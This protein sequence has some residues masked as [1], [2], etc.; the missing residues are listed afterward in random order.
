M[1]M[2]MRESLSAA[3]VLFFLMLS[4]LLPPR[5]SSAQPRPQGG[6]GELVALSKVA[7]SLG[8]VWRWER[9]FGRLICTRHPG[10]LRF[11]QDK[12]FY[13]VNGTVGKLPEAPRRIGPTLYLP[14]SLAADAFSQTSSDGVKGEGDSSAVVNLR[15]EQPNENIHSV[16]AEKKSNGTLVSIRLADSLPFDVTYFYPNLTLNFFGGK[17]DTA[18]IKQAQRIGLINSIS[19]IQFK[20]S[21]QVTAL[22]NHEIEEPMVEYMQ[23]TRTVMVALRPQKSKPQPSKAAPSPKKTAAQSG[24]TPIQAATPLS[25][26]PTVIVIDPGHGGKDPGAISSSGI[27]EKDVVLSIALKLREALLKKNGRLVIYMTREIDIFIPLSARTKFA[28][29]KKAHLFISIHA[30]SIAGNAKKRQST[31]GYKIYFLSQA[32]NEE[33]KLAAMRENAVIELEEQ[34]QNYSNLQNLL[35]EM[36]GNE[37][38]RESQDLCILF[39][40]EFGNSLGKKM[41]RLNRGVG[42]ANFWV[43]NGAFMPSILVETGF[44]SHKKEE[45]LLEDKT[46]QKEMAQAMSSAVIAFCEKYGSGI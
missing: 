33:D 27:L 38:L 37:F 8:Y 41:S 19:S 29:D 14:R 15:G 23:D 42:Q 12:C 13:Y 31:S 39:D 32:K 4:A 28:N 3:L 1:I 30:N 36:A 11:Y 5:D 35:I 7:D 45:K 17:I 2:K 20:G 34:P 6:D 21:A 10:E 25:A 26:G 24:K 40:Q 16:I 9:S 22:L 43:L 44:L 46:F 18:R